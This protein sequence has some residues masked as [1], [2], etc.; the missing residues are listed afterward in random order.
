MFFYVQNSE[1][2]D[3]A[4]EGVVLEGGGKA[5]WISSTVRWISSTIS[6]NFL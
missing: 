2:L 1:D 3:G 5:I 6:Y 4:L